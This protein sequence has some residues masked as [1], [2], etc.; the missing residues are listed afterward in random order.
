MDQQQLIDKALDD[1]FGDL[2]DATLSRQHV[3]HVLRT[4]AQRVATDAANAAL[5]SLLTTQD[6]AHRLFVSARR[7]RALARARGV[8]R[9]VSRG[10]WL[11]RPEDEERL[12]PG[13]PGR[14]RTRW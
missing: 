2:A 9:Q 14:R 7:V 4:L 8:G 12:R 6:M 1:L 13:P 5:M 11:F 3:E 10:T